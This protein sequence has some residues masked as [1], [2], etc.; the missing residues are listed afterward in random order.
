M[1]LGAALGYLVARA[2][3]GAGRLVER[4]QAGTTTPHKPDYSVPESLV[5]QG[6]FTRAIESFEELVWASPDLPDP[7]VR[8]AR[9]YRDKLD[10]AEEAER[11]FRRSRLDSRMPHGL[12]LLITQELI[13]LY[14]HKLKTPR[15]AIPELAHLCSAHAGTPAAEAAEHELREL[16]LMLAV[17][18]EGGE[19][20]T[21]QY[22]KK[23]APRRRSGAAEEPT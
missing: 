20:V 15:K 3:V 18:S 19:S 2:V 9:L 14:L 8:I 23:H 17:E 12:D 16:R 5:M 6:E 7:Y 1:L 10:Q 4:S 13:E 11:W 21:V 22:Q